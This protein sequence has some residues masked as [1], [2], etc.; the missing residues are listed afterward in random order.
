MPIAQSVSRRG[1]A[2]LREKVGAAAADWAGG[3]R[4]LVVKPVEV[5]DATLRMG[6]RSGDTEDEEE[7][8]ERSP[9]RRGTI[10]I[11]NYFFHPL[12][13]CSP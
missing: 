11:V 2:H 6:G 7:D 8:L 5:R 10:K 3:R 1:P 13:I 4:G 9:R 12:N